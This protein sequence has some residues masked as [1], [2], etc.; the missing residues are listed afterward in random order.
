M[1]IKLNFNERILVV[2]PHPDDES[3]GCGGLIIKYGEKC[4]VLLITDG[5]NGDGSGWVNKNDLVL[6]RHQEINDAMDIAGINKLYELK[7]PDSTAF[8]NYNI[9]KKF[10]I[11]DYQY[12]FIPN[13]HERHPDH[14]TLYPFF[15]K[16]IKNQKSKAQ[17]IDYEVWTPLR[18]TPIILDISGVI[19]RKKMMISKYQSQIKDMDYVSMAESL[20]RY[21]GICNNIEYAEA[22]CPSRYDSIVRNFFHWL[23]IKIQL[24][25]KS[26]LKIKV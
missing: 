6:I 19:G 25:I 1:N 9:V 11:K 17:L 23:P 13:R 5:R 12:I 4:D 22:F 18:Y 14:E 16:M 8:L 15:K 20:N 3:I 2:A 10:N 24:M 7:I 21:R 26:I